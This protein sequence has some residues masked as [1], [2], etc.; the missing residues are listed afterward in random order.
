MSI[1]DRIRKFFG[2]S[3]ELIPLPEGFDSKIFSQVMVRAKT[4]EQQTKVAH[5]AFY[6]ARLWKDGNS[7]HI[8]QVMA[9]VEATYPHLERM[10]DLEPLSSDWL[11]ELAT[12]MQ[13]TAE[14]ADDLVR[15]TEEI[16][17][18]L[19]AALDNSKSD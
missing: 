4:P 2:R 1:I 6:L 15:E 10:A 18:L 5:T 11:A 7:A 14:S 12:A 13:L 9:M 17:Q 19:R 3:D 8:P 16:D